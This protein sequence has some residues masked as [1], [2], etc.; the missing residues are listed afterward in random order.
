M[1]WWTAAMR[2]EEEAELTDAE[3]PASVADVAELK[4]QIEDLKSLLL[5]RAS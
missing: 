1:M 2:A 4:A 3:K 5:Q